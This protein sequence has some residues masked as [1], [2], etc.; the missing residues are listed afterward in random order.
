M[1]SFEYTAPKT[2]EEATGLLSDRWG[3]AEVLAGGTDL[4]TCMKQQ[5]AA[6]KRVVSLKNIADLKGI[7]TEGKALH[8]GATTTLGEL[9]ANSSVQE[10]FPALV[11]AAKNIMSPQ[12]LTLGTVGG[13]LLQRPR[14]WYYRNGFGL[15]GNRVDSSQVQLTGQVNATANIKQ[16]TSLV[17]EG[18]NRYHAIF[19]NDG[20]A[21]FVHPSSLAPVFVALEANMIVVG[22]KG[23]KREVAAAKFFQIPKSEQ[24]RESTLKPNEILVA[25]QVP[26]N[27]L[28][29]AVYEVRHRQTIDWPYVTAAVA[30]ASKGGSASDARVVLGHVAPIPWVSQGA[31]KALNRAT[32]SE[33]TAAKAGDAATQGAKPLSKNEYKIQLVRTA[34]KRAV[35]AAG[36]A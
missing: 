12:L 34:V 30:F 35:L 27:G 21:L 24:D 31:S 16:T 6:P 22:P 15:F 7:R 20:A 2:L 18:D 32:I 17:R 9:I 5:I 1:K 13:E 4:V 33:S 10:H 29:N 8:I 19:A 3:E 25:V 36:A 28:K 14:C 26:I 23:K 11:T